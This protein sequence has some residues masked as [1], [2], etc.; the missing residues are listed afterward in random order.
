MSH[1]DERD[2]D[3]AQEDLLKEG[4]SRIQQVCKPYSVEA[5]S[6]VLGALEYAQ[7]TLPKRRHINGKELLAGIL[8]YG[9]QQYGP[10]AISVFEHWGIHNTEDFGKIVFKMV[11]A[12]ILSKTDEDSLA[13]FKD[14]FDLKKVFG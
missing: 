8:S 3:Y 11:E 7:E 14:V 2:G 1:R 13:D 6:F 5:F 4:L 10:M 12:K 9:K